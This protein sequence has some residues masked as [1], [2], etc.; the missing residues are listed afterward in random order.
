L[1]EVNIIASGQ[2]VHCANLGNGLLEDECSFR[3]EY[4]FRN[5]SIRYKI[6]CEIVA[7]IK[8]MDDLMQVGF[9]KCASVSQR[10]LALSPYCLSQRAND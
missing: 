3:L 10:N 8:Q 1:Y 4:S 6:G 5:H 9:V 2:V 7:P